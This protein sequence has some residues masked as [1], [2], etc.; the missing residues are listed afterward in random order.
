MNFFEAKR[1]ILDRLKN[2]LPQHL[3]YHGYYHTM[4]VYAMTIDIAIKEGITDEKE[5]TMLKTAALFHDAGFLKTY[6]G[7]E[8]AGCQLVR[9]CLPNFG[10]SDLE[11]ELICGMIQATKIP[12]L[13]QNLLEE[14][15]ADADLDY[16]GREDFYQIGN[17]LFDELKSLDILQGEND[18][19]TLQV[20][21]LSSHN[22]FTKT[23]KQRRTKEKES[24]L[25]ELKN[26]IKQS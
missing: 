18:W 21:F 6:N 2:E 7:H 11:I 1:H 23:S 25:I 16:L 10:Y 8:I 24:R 3:T 15:I 20:Y 5:V 26:K 22:Y 19:N 17:L 9:E 12:Q 13:P 4:D 14:I